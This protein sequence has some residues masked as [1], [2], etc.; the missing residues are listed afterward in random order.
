MI[1][2]ESRCHKL[3][4]RD[5]FTTGKCHHQQ[6]IRPIYMYIYRISSLGVNLLQHFSS[7]GKD[8][9]YGTM[10]LSVALHVHLIS[11]FDCAAAHGCTC[12]SCICKSCQRQKTVRAETGQG[13]YASPRA[14]HS[15]ACNVAALAAAA[16]VAPE[17]MLCL[18][19]DAQVLL[20]LL[21]L[22]WVLSA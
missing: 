13:V 3:P 16:V 4:R 6:H 9:T 10:H 15:L 18:G 17:C 14:G 8:L 12:R 7:T 1:Q 2:L 5:L 21:G 19:R 11:N 20:L 22:V